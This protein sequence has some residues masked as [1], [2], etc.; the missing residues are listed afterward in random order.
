MPLV[1][2]AMVAGLIEEFGNLRRLVPELVE[3][4]VSSNAEIWYRGR[5]QATADVSYS[6]VAAFQTDMGPQQASARL[7]PRTEAPFEFIS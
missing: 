4:D 3:D 2:I 6:I 7:S 1:D 5:L